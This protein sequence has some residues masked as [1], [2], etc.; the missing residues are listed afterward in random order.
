MPDFV[1]DLDPVSFI[2]VGTI[3]P[4][5]RRTFYLQAS[6]GST[7]VSLIIEKEH[8]WALADSLDRLLEALD[9]RYPQPAGAAQEVNYDMALL[10][11]VNGR[12]RVGQI[13][14]GYDEEANLII[15]IA[16]ELIFEE[17]GEEDGKEPEVVRFTGTREQ[18]RALSRHAAW[19]VE[20]GRPICPLC[21]NPIDPAGHF[22]P[23]SN[24][25]RRP[26]EL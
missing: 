14:L 16:Q 2:T 22:C 13:G 24:G 12:W 1:Y 3:G 8:A 9:Q 7:V 10:Q 26:V 11:P 23:P 20:Q 15:L 19:L 18:M 5:G 4:P 6:Q 21:G 17:E 25:H